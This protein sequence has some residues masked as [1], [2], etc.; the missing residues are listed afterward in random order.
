MSTDVLDKVNNKARVCVRCNDQP[1]ESPRESILHKKLSWTI[2]TV[3]ILPSILLAGAIE[4]QA[5]LFCNFWQ[6][7]KKKIKS[8]AVDNNKSGE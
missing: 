1:T 6:T 4:N 7:E 8:S 2:I 5:D 3:N